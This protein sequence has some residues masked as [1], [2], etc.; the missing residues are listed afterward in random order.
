[1]IR[2]VIYICNQSGS[3]TEYAMTAQRRNLKNYWIDGRYQGRYMAAMVSTSAV[4]MMVFGLV[5][6][7]F[8]RDNYNTIIELFPVTQEMQQQ[9]RLELKILIF[10]I[11]FSSTVFLLTVAFISLV[12]SHKSAGPLYK[13]KN[14]CRQILSGD[15][16][17][18]ITL[19][20]GDDF[21]D[22]AEFVNSALD[23][24]ANPNEKFY[25][26]KRPRELMNVPLSHTRLKTLLMQGRI[27]METL[28][29]DPSNQQSPVSDLKTLL[30]RLSTPQG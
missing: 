27:K 17:T 6:Y 16:N 3:D 20:P 7:S 22:V 29:A 8:I 13:I 21:K 14:V 2:E 25:F 26:V 10:N 19:R 24:V 23:K 5:F 11:L 9:L 18:R 15:S 30:E 12:Y 1:M 4:C 28:V